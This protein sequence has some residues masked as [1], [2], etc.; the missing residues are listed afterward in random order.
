MHCRIFSVGL[1][2]F[3]LSAATSTAAIATAQ[4]T[5]VASYGND[6]NPC[7]CCSS[8]CLRWH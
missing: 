6:A 8:R 3:A 5:F 7:D 4:R 1:I 2:A